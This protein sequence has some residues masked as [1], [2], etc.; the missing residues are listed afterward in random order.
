MR[1]NQA[2]Q[3]LQNCGMTLS[4]AIHVFIQQ[5]L[6]GGGLPFIVTQHSREALRRQ[7]IARLMSK[8]RKGR[9]SVR[10]ESDWVSEEEM[11]THF[12][13]GVEAE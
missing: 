7:A 10:S 3:R 8:I 9:D 4:D 11:P 5:P 12:G 2:E 6:N 1:K 13:I